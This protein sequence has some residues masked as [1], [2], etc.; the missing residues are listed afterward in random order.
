MITPEMRLYKRGE[1]WYWSKGR[2][3]GQ[4]LRTKDKAVATRAFNVIKREVQ[5]GKIAQITSRCTKCLGEYSDEFMAWSEANQP[6]STSRANR[7]A[8]DKLIQHAGTTTALDRIS[9]KHLDLVITDCRKRGLKPN[10]INNYIRHARASLNKAAEWGY[11]KI[12]PLAKAKEVPKERKPPTFIEPDDVARFLNSIEDLGLRL[13]A[14][15]YIATGLRRSELLRLEWRD[16]NF[17]TGEALIR[18]SKT[19]LTRWIPI[20]A[21]FRA[22]LKSMG[23]EGR[24][25]V[26]SRW[27]YLDTVSKKVKTALVAHGLGNLSLHSLRHTYASLQ[28]DHGRTLLTVQELLGHTDPRTTQ[29]YVHLTRRHL[30]E[31]AE[32]RLGPIDLESGRK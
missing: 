4:S 1:I 25:R 8:L 26:C 11:V 19:H 10:S 5:A 32:V 28:I 22:V 14:T 3:H 27:S 2:G 9:L 15:A 16:I 12:N 7:L 21:Q 31:A 17:Q 6:H 24:G 23:G 20:N 29:I 13:I 30:K 18:K